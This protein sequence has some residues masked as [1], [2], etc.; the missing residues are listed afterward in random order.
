VQ[1]LLRHANV[2]T[3]MNLYA[4]AFTEDA[5][6]AQGRVID[7]VRMQPNL[8]AIELQEAPKNLIVQ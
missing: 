1:E 2:S 4:Q 5:R 3:T 8:A 6:A 7:L